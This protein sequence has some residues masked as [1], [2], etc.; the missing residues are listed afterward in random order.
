[1]VRDCYQR[2]EIFEVGKKWKM[3]Y[4]DYSSQPRR[5]RSKVWGKSV[6]P[7]R[8]EAQR[9]AD[10]HMERVN[11]RNNEPDAFPSDDETVAGLYARCQQITWPHLKN[12]TRS[13]YEFFF[14]TYIVPQWGTK[15]LRKLKTVEFQEWFNSFHPRLSPK[16]IRLMHAS[17]RAALSQAI[18]WGMLDRNPAV[19]VK[20]PRKH[21][22]KPTVLLSLYQIRQ[23][24][25]T[26]PEPTRSLV[27]LIVFASMRPGEVLA[28]RW[29]NVL[30]DRIVVDE[31]VYDDE[32]D[33]V[34][35]DAGKREVPF[36]RHGAI[37]ATLQGMWM[38]NTKFRKPD[39]LV[40]A[41][42]V[43]KPL[44]RHNL[45]HRHVKK[46]A[47]EL[48]LP[49]SVDFRSFR[50]MHASLMRRYGAR[51]EVARDNM[52]HAGSTGSITLDVYSKT[53]WDERVDAVTRV[54]D[55]VL[56]AQPEETE[57]P[58]SPVQAQNVEAGVKNSPGAEWVPFWVP[59]QEE[60]VVSDRKEW[61]ALADDFGTFVNS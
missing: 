25:E 16:T 54:V 52:G 29:K 10:E 9:L 58:S 15:K 7:S 39:D 5:K 60:E 18:A 38:K 11:A 41:N 53:W 35:T 37:L 36:D 26:L 34:K 8:R 43:G 32:F 21:T 4:W 55:A 24:I 14:S 19:G 20:L 23:M 42:K 56:A 61:S 30:P 46:T 49:T 31:R 44:D 51:L 47:E 2:P 12:S 1:V 27:A 17:L 6:V 28:L 40:F 50:T 33:D 57:A 45:L 48:K 3:V 22:V 13:H 59:Q